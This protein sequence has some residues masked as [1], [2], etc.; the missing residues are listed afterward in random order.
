MCIRDSVTNADSLRAT[1][2]DHDLAG[3][4]DDL[5]CAAISIAYGDDPNDAESDI[6]GEDNQ[7][8]DVLAGSDVGGPLGVS[9][10]VDTRLD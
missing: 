5:M 3:I 6:E 7:D 1:V 9:T 2:D 4:V 8:A 10:D